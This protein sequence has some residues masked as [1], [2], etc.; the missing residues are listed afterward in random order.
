MDTCDDGGLS[1]LTES[2]QG[3]HADTM[4]HYL[5]AIYRCQ[6]QPSSFDSSLC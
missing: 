5:L 6:N 2:S 1:W 4:D 3:Y